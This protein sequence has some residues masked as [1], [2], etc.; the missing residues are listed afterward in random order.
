MVPPPR[1]DATLCASPDEDAHYIFSSNF[2]TA[3]HCGESSAFGPVIRAADKQMFAHG[4]LLVGCCQL[5]RYWRFWQSISLLSRSSTHDNQ[6]CQDLPVSTPLPVGAS[7]GDLARIVYHD[8]I[9]QR[10]ISGKVE[11]V[12]LSDFSAAYITTIVLPLWRCASAEFIT[13]MRVSVISTYCPPIRLT[14]GGSSS[15]SGKYQPVTFFRSEAK[16]GWLNAFRNEPPN[17]NV[18]QPVAE[19]WIY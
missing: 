15:A 1:T 5:P 13:S 10:Q 14:V 16:I 3:C 12:T 9:F 17:L 8:A 4:G 11:R 18:F 19:I 7:T 6:R 2:F